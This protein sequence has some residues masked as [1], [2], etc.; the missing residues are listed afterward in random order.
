MKQE[1]PRE[2]T[3]IAKN[4]AEHVTPQAKYRRPALK[5]A[6]IP[7]EARN[8][9]LAFLR[10]SARLRARFL[11]SLGMTFPA[12]WVPPAAWGLAQKLA[13]QVVGPPRA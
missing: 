6:V 7:S 5:Q 11:A 8:L 13:M 9:A 1:I 2:F 10:R 4:K 3:K 12:F